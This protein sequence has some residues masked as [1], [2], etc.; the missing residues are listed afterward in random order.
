L[1]RLGR[2]PLFETLVIRTSSKAQHLELVMA[3][4]R[5]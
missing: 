4:P 3:P 2:T 1:P 5:V